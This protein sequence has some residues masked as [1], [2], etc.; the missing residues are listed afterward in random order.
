MLCKQYYRKW[1]TAHKYI[2]KTFVSE[3]KNVFLIFRD[4]C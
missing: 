2:S 4:K 1:S 3:L